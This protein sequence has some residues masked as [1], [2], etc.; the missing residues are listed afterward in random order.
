MDIEVYK[1]SIKCFLNL[2]N[3]D[4]K[5]FFKSCIKLNICKFI[6]NEDLLFAADYNKDIKLEIKWFEG[7]KYMI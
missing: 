5:V 7:L 4:R 6:G 1:M 2:E 3:D